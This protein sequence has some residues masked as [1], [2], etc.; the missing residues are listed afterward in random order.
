M[1]EEWHRPKAVREVFPLSLQLSLERTK[2]LQRLGLH[3]CYRTLLSTMAMLGS[4][5]QGGSATSTSEVHRPGKE[6]RLLNFRV[7]LFMIRRT[8]S[9]TDID[10]S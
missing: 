10:C 8:G 7:P 9:C 2:F 3:H 5:A 1:P 4:L 6:D